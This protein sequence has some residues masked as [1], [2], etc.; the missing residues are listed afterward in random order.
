MF[1]EVHQWLVEL[2]LMQCARYAVEYRLWPNS[3]KAQRQ[4]GLGESTTNQQ[5]DLSYLLEYDFSG[6]QVLSSR[7]L[8]WLA[9]FTAHS[10]FHTTTKTRLHAAIPAKTV[11][12]STN[13]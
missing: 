6:M 3:K 4:G 10:A 2:G 5:F 11:I 9:V 7:L 12:R 8:R 1:L 13:L